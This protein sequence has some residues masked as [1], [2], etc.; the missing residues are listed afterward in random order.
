MSAPVSGAGA[1]SLRQITGDRGRRAAQPADLQRHRTRRANL[2]ACVRSSVDQTRGVLHEWTD[3]GRRIRHLSRRPESALQPR[4]SRSGSLRR[5]AKKMNGLLKFVS[6]K[7]SILDRFAL[8]E[9]GRLAMTLPP[10][11]DMDHAAISRRRLVGPAA[12]VSGVGRPAW[13]LRF[14]GGNGKSQQISVRPQGS[15]WERGLA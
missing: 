8:G 10:A 1:L 14:L 5:T 15:K 12:P 3:P 9:W 13:T 4:I 7:R 2:R 11:K 6:Q